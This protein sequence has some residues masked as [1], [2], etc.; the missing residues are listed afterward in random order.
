MKRL[1]KTTVGPVRW[2]GCLLLVLTLAPAISVGVGPVAA[3]P[4]SLGLSTLMATPNPVVIPYGTETGST[5][6]AWNSGTDVVPELWVPD[7][8]SH[9]EMR[10]PGIMTPSGTYPLSV[11]MGQGTTVSLYLPGH[12]VLLNSVTVTTQRPSGNAV[13]ALPTPDPCAKLCTASMPPSHVYTTYRSR[14]ETDGLCSSPGV[15]GTMPVGGTDADVPWDTIAVGFHHYYDEGS[16]IP[17]TET[18]DIFFRG[19]VRFDL[20]GFKND[21]FIGA[22]L[23]FR[24]LD[25]QR[26]YDGL[27]AVVPGIWSAAAGVDRATDD[28][29][30]WPAHS[31]HDYLNGDGAQQFVAPERLDNATISLD[32]SAM[33][34]DWLAGATPN[35]GFVFY[36]KDE[37]YPDN[38]EILISTYTDFTLTLTYA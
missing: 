23:T 26:R 20:H 28:W 9:R 10:L 15:T 3:R 36:G 4:V 13:S 22:K 8:A 7:R 12:D 38:S 35:Y 17:C 24:V 31:N 11:R 21:H 25:S 33:V 37:G 29:P 27:G 2:L 14:D 32:V 6:I 19:A 34:R 5:M 30:D 16:F 18:D 1:R